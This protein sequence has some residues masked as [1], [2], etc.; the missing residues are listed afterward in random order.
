MI[1]LV[2]AS[3]LVSS[4]VPFP[5]AAAAVVVEVPFEIVVERPHQ[6]VE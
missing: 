3:Q 2:A 6:A 1:G 4:G 5:A